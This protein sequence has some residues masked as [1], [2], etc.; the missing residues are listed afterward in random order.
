MVL[1]LGL[2][3]CVLAGDETSTTSRGSE[4]GGDS[5]GGGCDGV[6]CAGHPEAHCPDGTVSCRSLDAGG[7]LECTDADGNVSEVSCP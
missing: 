1:A 5:Y 3:G 7:T 2:V 4:T 6:H